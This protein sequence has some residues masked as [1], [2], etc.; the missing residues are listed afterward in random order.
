[1]NSTYAV[2]NLNFKNKYETERTLK[3]INIIDKKQLL[4]E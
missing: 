1:M 4:I 3:S 2:I